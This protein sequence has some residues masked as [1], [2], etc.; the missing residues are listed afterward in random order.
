[1]LTLFKVLLEISNN[2]AQFGGG[3]FVE[4]KTA[5]GSLCSG[6]TTEIASISSSNHKCFIQTIRLYDLE[7][8][9]N[10]YVGKNLLNIFITNNTATISGNAIFG[11]LFDRCTVS[12]QAEAEM[13]ASNGL[14]YI[15]KIVAFENGIPPLG[16]NPLCDR[17]WRKNHQMRQQE[18]NANCFYSDNWSTNM[19]HKLHAL[20]YVISKHIPILM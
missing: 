5:G 18:T 11:G 6:S 19:P 4:D 9:G 12:L 3:I 2:S 1:M 13:F 10:F 15:S 7:S 8:S 16:H 17:E 14:D 20:I